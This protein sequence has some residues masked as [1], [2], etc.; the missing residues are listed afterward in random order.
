MIACLILAA[1]VIGLPLLW[2]CWVV[3]WGLFLGV[4]RPQ[5]AKEQ[6]AYDT[7]VTRARAKLKS[8]DPFVRGLAAYELERLAKMT[9]AEYA[10]RQ[11]E[12]S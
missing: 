12:V 8:A 7:A 10:R 4:P 2:L 6:R 1:V 9:P 3:L 11:G 5:G